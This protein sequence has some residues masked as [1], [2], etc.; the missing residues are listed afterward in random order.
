MVRASGRALDP[1]LI[2]GQRHFNGA[3]FCGA[4]EFINF[5]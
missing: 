4:Q 1:G 5:L 3:K 2:S